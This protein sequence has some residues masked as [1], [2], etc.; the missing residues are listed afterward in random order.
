MYNYHF[1][2]YYNPR[3]TV[4]P[5]FNDALNGLTGGLVA[6][7]V[8]L[9]L[10]LIAVLIILIIAECKVFAKAGEKWWKALI[11]VYNSWVQIKFAGLA[12]WWFV[13]FCGLS[14]LGAGLKADATA[15]VSMLLLLTSFNLN[16]NLARK[17]GKGNGYAFLCTFLPFIGYPMLAFGS[18]TYDKDVKVDK[19]GIFSVE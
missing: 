6:L 4:E 12:W 13:I 3:P 10:V 15:I 16:Y 17:F 2:N 11:P 8:I 9:I 18:A 1:G 5:S 7:A 14:L 19:N